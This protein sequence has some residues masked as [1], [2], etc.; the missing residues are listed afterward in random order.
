MPMCSRNAIVEPTSIAQ[1][2]KFRRSASIGETVVSS[3]P[4]APT[5]E[6]SST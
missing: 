4:S 6:W 5:A 3:Q 1:N 2:Q